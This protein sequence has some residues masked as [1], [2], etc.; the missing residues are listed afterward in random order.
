M[1]CLL[2]PKYQLH[3][4]ISAQNMTGL[5][6]AVIQLGSGI[7]EHHQCLSGMGMNY[8]YLTSLKFLFWHAL[9][10]FKYYKPQI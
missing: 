7:L 4:K 1:D 2:L 8:Y 3:H 10:V 5:L 6:R 9:N